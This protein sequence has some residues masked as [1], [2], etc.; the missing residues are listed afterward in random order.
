MEKRD[1][2]LIFLANKVD[3]PEDPEIM[4]VV[5]EIRW[6][7]A[8]IIKKSPTL[9]FSLVTSSMKP[10]GQVWGDNVG[11][12]YKLLTYARHMPRVVTFPMFSPLLVWGQP[13]SKISPIRI[14]RWEYLKKI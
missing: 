10:I 8:D 12:T 3:E 2:P 13:R 5:E 11:P 4:R 7:S 6:E 14:V 9:Q 1:I